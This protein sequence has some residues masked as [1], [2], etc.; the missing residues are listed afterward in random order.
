MTDDELLYSAN[1]L[2]ANL[3][4]HCEALLKRHSGKVVKAYGSKMFVADEV[5]YRY[6]YI[7]IG[8]FVL[9]A[10]GEPGVR[11]YGMQL[12]DAEFVTP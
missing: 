4:E 11:R 5:E 10:N 7:S 1:E 12:D 8:G 6:G 9:K 2:V 3:Q